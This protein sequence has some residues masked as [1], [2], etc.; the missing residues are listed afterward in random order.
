MRSDTWGQSLGGGMIEQGYY[1]N[2]MP[3]FSILLYEIKT[4]TDKNG[5]V[6]SK[7]VDMWEYDEATRA[8]MNH[9][10]ETY[11]F[12]YLPRV[13]RRDSLVLVQLDETVYTASGF[14]IGDANTL[15]ERTTTSGYVIYDQLKSVM[16]LTQDQLAAVHAKGIEAVP[17]GYSLSIERQLIPDSAKDWHSAVNKAAVVQKTSAPQITLWRDPI[18]IEEIVVEE[19]WQ[20]I[21][22]WTIKKDCLRDTPPEF[23][24]KEKL[25]NPASLQYP[26]PLTAPEFTAGLSGG[27]VRCEAKKGGGEYKSVDR[28]GGVYKQT[29][30]PDKYAF[31]RKTISLPS[32]PATGNQFGIWSEDPG[33]HVL[34]VGIE[35]TAV[36]DYAGATVNP[37]PAQGVNVEPDDPSPLPR[38]GWEMVGEAEAKMEELTHQPK[39]V[40]FDA[41]VEN[42]AVYEYYAVAVIGTS[43]S[44]Q[45]N[46][47]RVG[48]NGP[49]T[50]TSGI[51][52]KVFTPK[53]TDGADGTFN[54]GSGGTGPAGTPIPLYPSKWAV[55]GDT[56]LLVP[57]VAAAA[58]VDV[59]GPALAGVPDGY[60]E[61]ATMLLPV[62]PGSIS[63][64][65]Q[66][67][68]DVGIRQMM[69]NGEKY[70]VNI[71]PSAP[72]LPLERGMFMR[73]PGL[74]VETWGAG[75]HMT[76]RVVPETLVVEAFGL[77]AEAIKDPLG[78]R[79]D[80]TP[81]KITLELP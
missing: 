72:I 63:E 9:K 47:L 66:I 73:L 2:P 56:G 58:I 35:N 57:A 31:Y 16:E 44:P 80:C 77:T 18:K 74:T 69:Q 48:Y 10:K 15:A 39:G 25:K 54:D 37:L 46:H 40:L 38:F 55:G 8:P 34:G 64:L 49:S 12:V 45:S 33:P 42:G 7:T 23:D 51:T 68:V 50:N 27:A 4:L 3:P 36:K 61:V 6:L 65:K 81:D 41:N 22:T 53:L 67:G 59:T 14:L 52:S 43:E 75:L 11:A 70:T 29:V 26:I 1:D 28:F 20:K 78:P 79:F 5:N 71:T 76:T 30:K 17:K 24:R 13:T 21:V 60:G 32:R 62:A 19:D